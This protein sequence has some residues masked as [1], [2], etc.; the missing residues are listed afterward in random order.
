MIGVG[1]LAWFSVRALVQLVGVVVAMLLATGA[2]LREVP[3]RW[4][5][6]RALGRVRPGCGAS[7][8]FCAVCQDAAAD[9]E[10]VVAAYRL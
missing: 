3:Q 5:V 9:W 2:W 10:A 8:C 6:W 4:R 1:L 7:D